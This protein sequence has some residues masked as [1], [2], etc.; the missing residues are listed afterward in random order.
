V[1]VSDPIGIF[2]DRRVRAAK[3]VTLPHK[4]GVWRIDVEICSKI[5]ASSSGFFGKEFLAKKAGNRE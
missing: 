2:P 1:T 5:Q 4:T 3:S